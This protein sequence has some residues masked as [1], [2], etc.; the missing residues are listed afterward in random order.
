MGYRKRTAMGLPFASAGF[1]RNP[2]RALIAHAGGP[3]LLRGARGPRRAHEGVS[4]HQHA[5]RLTEGLLDIVPEGGEAALGDFCRKLFANLTTQGLDLRLARIGLTSGEIEA[6]FAPAS[7]HEKPAIDDM[8]KRDNLDQWAKA[9][10]L[11][12]PRGGETMRR[13]SQC[14][15]WLSFC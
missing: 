15:S 9:S 8:E 5:V 2:W 6:V 11:I 3:P 12:L 4:G 7:C 13:R 14:A 10:F 1:T